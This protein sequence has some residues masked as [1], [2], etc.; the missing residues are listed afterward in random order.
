[1][2]NSVRFKITQIVINYYLELLIIQIK[3]LKIYVNNIF[4]GTSSLN[5]NFMFTIVNCMKTYFYRVGFKRQTFI[6]G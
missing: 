5:T 1:M 4:M 6:G 2:I 3:Q